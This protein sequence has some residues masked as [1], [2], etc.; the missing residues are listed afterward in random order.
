MNL[1][2][3]PD[4]PQ[5]ERRRLQAR[6][7]RLEKRAQ[8]LAGAGRI[9]EAI[10]CQSEVTDLRP[11]DPTAFFRLGLMYR[12]ARRIDPAVSALRR[13]MDLNPEHRDPREALI[14]TL[15][16]GGRFGEI[17]QETKLLVKIEPRSIFARDV[18]SLAYMQL[19]HTDKALRVVGELI[20]LDPIN[21]DHYL[22]RAMLFQQQNDWNHAVTEYDR[23]LEMA[24]PDSDAYAV[25]FEALQTLDE[26]QLQQIML[27]AAED[28]MF[29]WKATRDLEE[30]IQERGYKLTE[31][32]VA[33]LRFLLQNQP[34]WVDAMAPGPLRL[35]N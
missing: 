10:A 1:S 20:W 13:A 22:K 26:T 2:V 6:A 7:R 3:S 9:D 24:S 31:E 16:D 27:L 32:G 30:A 33:R 17:V 28:R 35:Y 21:P 34:P 23:I 11:N 15:L 19:G 14:A 25:A 18:L 4:I 12:E 8:T 29:L 5:S